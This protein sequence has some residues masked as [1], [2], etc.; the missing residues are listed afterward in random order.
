[1]NIFWKAF[2]TFAYCL[3][4]DLNYRKMWCSLRDVNTLK[5]WKLE[6]CLFYTLFGPKFLNGFGN[7]LQ[8]ESQPLT[9]GIKPCG[10]ISEQ[11]K[12]LYTSYYPE[13]RK[14]LAFDPFLTLFP[15]R[16]GP[17]SPK[18]IPTFLLWYWTVLITE[19]HSLKLKL[20]SG[21]QMCLRTTTMTKIR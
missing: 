12:Y 2:F 18:S 7:Y 19:I 1:M 6:K 8:N 10:T 21:N 16:L 14:M 3:I 17:S 13:T 15:K 20:L 5:H 9:C 4:D 11:S